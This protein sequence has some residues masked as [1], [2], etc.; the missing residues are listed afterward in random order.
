MQNERTIQNYEWTKH[1]KPQCCFSGKYFFRYER[2]PTDA[3][4]LSIYNLLPYMILILPTFDASIWHTIFLF[5]NFYI[6][7]FDI[8]SFA[9]YNLLL[10]IICLR[11]SDI[12]SFAVRT[13]VYGVLAYDLL[14]YTIIL[15]RTFA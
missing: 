7:S 11:M 9:P 15:S 6:R 10:T 14:A 2:T 13:F 5:T 12:R 4:H 3:C 1:S 8:R